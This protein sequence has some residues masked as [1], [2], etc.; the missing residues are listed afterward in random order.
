MAPRLLTSRLPLSAVLALRY[1]RSTRRD[2][3]TT[4]LSAV[5]VAAITVG[6]AALILSLA[7][8]SGFQH[9]LR[10]EIL[11]ET[12]D[13]E[14][15]LPE[16]LGAQQVE[17]VVEA[18]RAVGGVEDVR[19]VV[20]GRGWLLASGRVMPAEVVGFTGALPPA[21][22]GAVAAEP[23]PSR[24]AEGGRGLWLS[25]T[26]V[27]SWLLEPGDVVE[28]VSPRPTLTPM[29]PRP[30][31]R[32]VPLAGTFEGGRTAERERAAVPLEVAESLFGPGR[33]RLLVAAGGPEGA[34]A[35]AGRLRGAVPAGAEVSTWRDLNRPLF[36]ALR[37]ERVFLFLGVSLIV[38]VAALAL[39]ADLALI[40]ANKRRDMGMLLT[41]G[42]TPE[43]LRRAFLT[44]GALLASAGTALGAAAGLGLAWIFDRSRLLRLPGEVFFVEYVPFLVRPRDLASIVAL[45][46]TLALAASLYGAHRAAALDPVEALRR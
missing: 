36:F 37:L 43:R 23:G 16:G 41:M 38:L 32:S 44:L 13:L 7:A 22:P 18:V 14:I 2:A 9:V 17:R 8:L 40:I 29:G 31:V 20:R 21:F 46:L 11:A 39:L 1:L 33:R 12:P 30:R 25:R 3:F 42:A 19:Q 15:E 26:L 24:D 34:L 27:G 28:V 45:T 35:V 6:V 5:A 10:S 4:F